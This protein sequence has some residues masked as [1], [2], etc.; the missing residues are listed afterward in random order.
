[1]SW[2]CTSIRYHGRTSI[3]LGARFL[4]F[5]LL[6]WATFPAAPQTL[7]Y[8]LMP[9]PVIE[10]HADL[11]TD[12]RKCHVVFSPS[13]Q[14]KLCMNCHEDIG[15]DIAG[16]HGYHG[17]ME[18]AKCRSCHTDHKGREA[19]IVKLDEKIFDHRMTDFLLFGEHPNANCNRCHRPGKKHREAPQDCRDCHYDQDVHDEE[20]GAQCEQCHDEFGWKGAEFDHSVTNFDLWP[21]HTD[22][23]CTECHAEHFY[24]ETPTECIGCHLK[25]DEHNGHFG[26]D[27]GRCHQESAWNESIF[28]HDWDTDYALRGLHRPVPCNK[29][30]VQPLFETETTTRCFDCHRKKDIHKSALGT[31]CD[32]CHSELDWSKLHFDHDL[33]SRFGLRGAH[34]KTE[35]G[36]CHKDTKYATAPP[37]LCVECHRDDDFENGHRGKFGSSCEDCHAEDNWKSVVFDHDRDTKYPLRWRHRPVT[38]NKCHI[39]ALFVHKTPTRCVGCHDDNDVHKAALGNECDKCHSERDWKELHFE[40]DRDSRFSLRG[41][42]V[43]TECR[44]CHKDAEYMKMP[45]RSCV[46]CHRLDDREKGHR[47]RFGGRCQD[48]HSERNWRT[49]AFDHR[50]VTNYPLLGKHR[51]VACKGCH[52]GRLYEDKV[53]TQCNFCHEKDDDHKGELGVSCENCHTE[54]DWKET[55]FDHR[56]SQ[57]PL[58]GK[59]RDALCDQ[60]HNSGQYKD[61][62]SECIACHA[63][64]DRHEERLG[65]RCGWCHDSS[66]WEYWKYDHNR[67]TRFRLDGAHRKA[68]CLACHTDRVRGKF[69]VPTECYGCHRKDDVHFGTLSIACDACHGVGDWRGV[70]DKARLWA[71]QGG[72]PSGGKVKP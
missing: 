62:S 17:K 61:S 65:P 21:S 13:S 45:P 24:D 69:I 15:D 14:P 49:T 42:H 55:V 3:G 54:K 72:P 44:A 32:Q 20:L 50:R 40:H 7:E 4:A 51:K 70:S 52:E 27:C 59:H 57:F 63:K 25:S 60:C 35:C 16:E 12:C 10:G 48:C 64:E 66:S 58:S 9:G 11:E 5:W 1:M 38:C 23:A 46:Q 56:N 26:R 34:E 37:T 47:S 33:D 67:L 22:V 6:I 28:V 2:R 19:R 39:E 18:K 36:A 41:A 29:C 53:N 43:K 31:E 8:V 71:E 68:K 30:H